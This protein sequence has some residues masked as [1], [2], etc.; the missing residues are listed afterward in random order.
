MTNLKYGKLLYILTSV[1]AVVSGIFLIALCAHLFFTGGEMPYSRERVGEYLSLFVIPAAVTVLL[2]VGGFVY[3]GLTGRK[4]DALAARTSSELLASYAPRVDSE[5]LSDDTKAR[6]SAE[7]SKRATY[8]WV[9]LGASCVFILGMVLYFI[10][11]TEFTVE[12]LNS[13]VLGALAGVL[14]LGVFAVALHIPKAYLTEASAA[15]ELELLKEAVKG[16]V[17]LS[18]PA[19]LSESNN[20]K[21]LVLI[22]RI[23]I[24]C[25]GVL[26]IILGFFNGGM[27]DVLQKAIKICTECIGLG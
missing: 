7:R 19:S 9:A 5:A 25:V 26:F 23:A 4:K 16:G 18:K 8:K 13:D 17:A 3:D 20:E 27:T 15:R 22:A 14:P 10:L 1:F 11:C 6:I 21:K 12:N 24:V 2:I